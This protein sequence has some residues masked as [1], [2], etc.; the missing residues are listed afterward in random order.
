MSR[1]GGAH[2]EKRQRE[3]DAQYEDGQRKGRMGEVIRRT[4]GSDEE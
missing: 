2:R 3:T 4:L 1:F